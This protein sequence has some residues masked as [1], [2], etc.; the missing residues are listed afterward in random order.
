[1]HDLVTEGALSSGGELLAV[2]SV[3]GGVFEEHFQWLVLRVLHREERRQKG[4]IREGPQVHLPRLA[5][6]WY[7][8]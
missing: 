8:Y 2:E 4:S 3:N 6:P 7:D 1:M 5:W